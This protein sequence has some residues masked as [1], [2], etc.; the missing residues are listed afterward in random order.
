VW[1]G[2]GQWRLLPPLLLLQTEQSA[3]AAAVAKIGGMF[4]V[5]SGIQV[6]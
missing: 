4:F 5:S 1:K 3:S 6:N 2:A